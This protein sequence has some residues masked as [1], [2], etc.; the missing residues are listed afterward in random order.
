MM[1]KLKFSASLASVLLAGIGT[2]AIAQYSVS[3]APIT[4]R[5]RAALFP[6]TAS[7]EQGRALADTTCAACHGIDGIS[8]D[9]RRPHLAGQR[10]IY[11]YRE[12][13]AYQQGARENRSMQDA[14]AFLDADALLKTAIYYATLSPP[15][16]E[17][18]GESAGEALDDDPLTAVKSATAGC[19]SCHGP[20][21]NS[22]IPGMPSLTGQSPDYFV[23]SMKAYQS[24]DRTDNMMQMLVATLDDDTIS[25]MGLF[26]ALQEPA[27]KA[28]ATGGDPA[29]GAVA[30]EACA[31][32][33][34]SDG[35]ASGADMP[36]LAGQDQAYLVKAMQAY[37]D[38]RREHGAMQTAM[39]GFEDQAINDMAA[40][41]ATQ[42]PLARPVR[43]PL[44]AGEWLDR[45]DRCHGANGNSND[46][47]YSRLAG[48]N[49]QYLVDVLKAYTSG[50]RSDSIMHAMSAPLNNRVIERLAAYYAAQD[51]RSV[52]YFELPCE[53]DSS[54]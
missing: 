26:Y 38:G 24:G 21:G 14:V 13:L 41:Y 1:N 52:V 27:P 3:T 17:A 16:P 54:Q 31:N 15:V 44:T 49:R 50:A 18:I 2:A 37:L 36:T 23:Q 45:C 33:H 43:K 34:G 12:M 19:G 29:A 51:P 5:E 32:C 20:N 4:A 30:A 42:E 7:I 8:T 11:L 48:Q 28:V 25:S 10:T 39:A 22:T 47:R 9:E 40:F 35:N 6:T 53:D 46:P